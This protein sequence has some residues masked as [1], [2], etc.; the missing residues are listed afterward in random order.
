MRILFPLVVVI[1]LT[2]LGLVGASSSGGQF[3][4]GVIVPYL[5]IGLFLVG[6]I[7]RVL[8]WAR[9]PVPFRIPTT[10]GQ[11]R[12]LPWIKNNELESPSNTW[13]VI[14][15]MFLEVF[16]FRSLFRNTVAAVKPGPKL[17]YGANKFLWAGAI[18]FHYAFLVI[19]L[20]HFRFFTEPVPGFVLGLQWVDGFFQVWVPPILITN[21]LIL[22][23]LL[24]LWGRRIF[25]GQMRHLSLA[26][27]HFP[28]LLIL[29]IVVTGMWMRYL[30]KTDLLGVKQLA[31]GIVSFAPVVPEGIAPLFFAHLLLV[32]ILFAY[33]P[34]S[35]LV[36]LGG[37]FLSPTRNLAN[38]NR[39]K[40]HINPWNYPVKVHTYDEYEDEFKDLMKAADMPVEKE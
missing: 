9:V 27:D 19:F 24:Y 28:L 39:A 22:G 12:S 33:F 5:A 40:R 18:V 26:G 32:S 36:H 29:G 38:N 4:I 20:R 34:F 11:Q 21:I 37:V 3:V 7:W 10:C 25:T 30:D 2:V 15:R 13:G 17:V 31:M 16:F 23:A 6:I 8:S 35:K 1:V 14:K